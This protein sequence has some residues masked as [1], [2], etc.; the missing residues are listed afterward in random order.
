M[1]HEIRYSLS[2]A[3]E[4]ELPQQIDITRR[5]AVPL[6]DG[7]AS[8]IISIRSSLFL[9][10]HSHSSLPL[11][12]GIRWARRA[13][14]LGARIALHAVRIRQG[15]CGWFRHCLAYLMT[16]LLVFGLPSLRTQATLRVTVRQRTKERL[17]FRCQFNF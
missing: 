9:S 10:V 5:L 1:L 2:N 4:C 13:H 6:V 14:I 17:L 15:A 11:P 7:A 3:N 16:L 12:R 8:P